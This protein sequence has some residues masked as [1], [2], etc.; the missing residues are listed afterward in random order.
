MRGRG[1][2]FSSQTNRARIVTLLFGFVGFLGGGNRIIRGTDYLFEIY[3]SEFN[4]TEN[5]TYVLLDIFLIHR[6][7]ILS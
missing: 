2:D 6:N 4:L 7:I 1:N 3:F 5:Y